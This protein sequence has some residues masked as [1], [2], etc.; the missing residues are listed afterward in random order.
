MLDAYNLVTVYLFP[1][2]L[3]LTVCN[4]RRFSTKVKCIYGSYIYFPVITYEG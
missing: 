4:K 1:F 3:L 2:Q